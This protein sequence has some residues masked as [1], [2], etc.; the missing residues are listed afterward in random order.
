MTKLLDSISM[1][2]SHNDGDDKQE[3]LE[4]LVRNELVTWDTENSQS[5]SGLVNNVGVRVRGVYF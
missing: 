1:Q 5:R 2:S 3:S 4:K